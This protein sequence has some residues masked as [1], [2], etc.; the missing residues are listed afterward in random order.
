MDD[1]NL[2]DGF[3]EG[4]I[5]HM[6]AF[7]TSPKDSSDF[8][9]VAAE[10]EEPLTTHSAKL[11]IKLPQEGWHETPGRPTLQEWLNRGGVP[12]RSREGQ[13]IFIGFHIG[14]SPVVISLGV[15][16]VNLN[17]LAEVFYGRL[18]FAKFDV[19]RS[20]VVKS[21]GICWIQTN[22]LVKISYGF[23]GSV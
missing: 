19:F 18:M 3:I 5:R 23:L 10:T 9:I 1:D 11:S 6:Y 15:I 12:N 16:G 22:G 7:D 17:G 13:L 14:S 2:A 4:S 8:F 20:P 21:F